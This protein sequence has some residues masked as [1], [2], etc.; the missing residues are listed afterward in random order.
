MKNDTDEEICQIDGII[1]QDCDGCPYSDEYF[2]ANGICTK[3][4]EGK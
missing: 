2:N 1:V 4:G 3:K